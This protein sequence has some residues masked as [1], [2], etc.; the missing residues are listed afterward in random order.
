VETPYAHLSFSSK[1]SKWLDEDNLVRGG[2]ETDWKR[3]YKLRHN[4]SKGQCDVSE[5]QVAEERPLPPLLVRLHEGIVYTADSI[6]G[7]R[8]WDSKKE[9]KLLGSFQFKCSTPP[10]AL[11]IDMQPQEYGKHQMAVA[12]KDGSFLLFKFSRDA[13]FENTSS[14]PPSSNGM[15]IAVAL[16]SPFLLTMTAVQLL[17][18]YRIPSLESAKLEPP[19][20][21]QSLRSH[22][23]WPPLS[24]SLR[25]ASQTFVATIAYA[26]PTILNWTVGIQ[27]MRLSSDGDLLDSRLATSTSDSTTLAATLSPSLPSTRSASP[28]SFTAA[29]PA[30]SKP[31]SLSYTHPYLLLSHPDNTLTLYL[32]TSNT[33]SLSISS[34]TRLWGHTSSVSG[35]HV[36]GRG[37]AVSVSSHGEELRIWELEGSTSRRR[38][39]G[40]G[41]SVKVQPKAAFEEA[42]S[43]NE[44]VM[45]GWVGFDD[46]R[47]IVL[48]ERTLGR[49]NLVVYDFT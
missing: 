23:V 1:L 34:G 2:K 15:L 25:P 39:V 9:G 29:S 40:G 44:G 46:E 18:L 24:L 42:E 45:R 8:A 7:L 21:L 41:W 27:E 48:K 30:F 14:H 28:V 11:A 49:Q 22:T 13:L 6:A 31:T 33:Q 43:E 5:I 10:T 17:S 19:R 26:I 32:V 38:T 37:K 4:W 3:Q 36:E 47:V 35:A 20:L 12:F 16:C